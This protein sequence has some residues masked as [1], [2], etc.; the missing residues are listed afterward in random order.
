MIAVSVQSVEALPFLEHVKDREMPD[1]KLTPDL[2]EGLDSTKNKQGGEVKGC[3][4]WLG[5]LC[6]FYWEKKN[7]CAKLNFDKGIAEKW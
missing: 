1:I 6:K 4:D 7:A 2:S 5:E 3:G